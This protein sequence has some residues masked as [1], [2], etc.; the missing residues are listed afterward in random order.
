MVASAGNCN[1]VVLVGLHLSESIDI[2][3]LYRQIAV[4]IVHA[5]L[6]IR[7][8]IVGHLEALGVVGSWLHYGHIVCACAACGHRHGGSGTRRRAGR[9]RSTRAVH[10]NSTGQ[11]TAV[12]ACHLH[13]CH[14]RTRPQLERKERGHV[15][16]VHIVLRSH[17]RHGD[18][19]GG[20]G[21]CL[22]CRNSHIDRRTVDRCISRC[23]INGVKGRLAGRNHS[24]EF[25]GGRA[26][27][28]GKFSIHGRAVIEDYL[29]LV[30][31]APDGIRSV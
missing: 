2:V 15:L 30:V 1:V 6:G 9:G 18:V 8:G 12:N 22:G 16:E 5:G 28:V 27:A 3:C 29:D 21:A 4:E 20:E 14:F 13:L 25:S 26:G 10:G 7:A 23:R 11:G 31:L 17:L 24:F 19:A